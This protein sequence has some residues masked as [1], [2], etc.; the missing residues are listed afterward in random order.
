MKI[1]SIGCFLTA[2]VFAAC[3]SAE[4]K[5]A[6]NETPI[7]PANQ[8]ANIAP[9]QQPTNEQKPKNAAR[10]LENLSK[11]IFSPNSAASS[12]KNNVNARGNSTLKTRAAPDDSDFYSTINNQGQPVEVRVFKNNSQLIKAERIYVT[13]DKKII[14]ISLKNGRVVEL[15]D[16]QLP[17][18]PAAS[19]ISIINAAKDKLN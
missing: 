13:P 9:T 4:N 18:F 1:L 5:N 15:T 11:N 6:A 8:T 14:R 17:N 2:S 16:E 12:A 19:A 10:D 3:S 7:S